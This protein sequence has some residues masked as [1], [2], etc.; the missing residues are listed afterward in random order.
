MQD[1]HGFNPAA[2]R[3]KRRKKHDTNLTALKAQR[4]LAQGW[5]GATT[6]GKTPPIIISALKGRWKS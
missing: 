5:R 3:H 1:R 4:R 6:L 2:K